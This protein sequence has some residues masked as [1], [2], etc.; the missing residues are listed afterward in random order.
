MVFD[1]NY[2]SVDDILRIGQFQENLNNESLLSSRLDRQLKNHFLSYTTEYQRLMSE[3]LESLVFEN[4]QVLID[5]SLDNLSFYH[6]IKNKHA[7]LKT[8][9]KKVKCYQLSQ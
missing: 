9:L 1:A 5:N 3:T 4:N 8:V 7:F 6:D 2:I